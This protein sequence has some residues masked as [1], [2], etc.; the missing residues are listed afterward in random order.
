[1]KIVNR[2]LTRYISGLVPFAKIVPQHIMHQ[3]SKDMSKKS[4][5]FALDVIMKNERRR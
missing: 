2:T 4:A 3:Y 5:V 1:M